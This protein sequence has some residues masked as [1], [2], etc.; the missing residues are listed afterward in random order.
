M[1]NGVGVFATIEFHARA[2]ASTAGARV[3][4]K[5]AP[6]KL[7]EL[8]TGDPQMQDVVARV[9]KVIGK[10]IPILIGGETGAGKEMLARAIH[11]DSPRGAGAPFVA[12]NCAS[13]PETLIESEL[14][15]YAQGA[16]TGAAKRGATGK[17]VQADGG[18][19][20]R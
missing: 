4:T 2:I 15:G 16:F 6:S 14:F 17:I 10:R 20:P 8:C 5:P 1:H 7:A 3:D 9:R 19:V 12:V 13:L 11:R 18:A